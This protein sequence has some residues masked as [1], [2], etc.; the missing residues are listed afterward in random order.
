MQNEGDEIKTEFRKIKKEK[1]NQISRTGESLNTLA[2]EI[3]NIIQTISILE[4]KLK[5]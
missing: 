4:A 1:Q 3:T 5:S 2:F